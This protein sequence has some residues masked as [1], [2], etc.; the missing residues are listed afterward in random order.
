MSQHR[1]KKNGSYLWMSRHAIDRATAA[2]GSMAALVYLGL[3]YLE[4]RTKHKEAFFASVQNIAATCKIGTRTVSRFLPILVDAGLVSVQS[5][6]RNAKYSTFE[7]SKYTLVET[8]KPR[9]CVAN[10]NDSEPCAFES[11]FKGQHIIPPLQGGDNRKTPL[12]SAPPASPGAAHGEEKKAL[13]ITFQTPRNHEHHE[14]P[15]P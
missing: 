7:A 3:C 8:A 10:G 15:N 5:G 14:P 9:A 13:K 6:R 11:G 2:G 12:L 1:Q 4:S